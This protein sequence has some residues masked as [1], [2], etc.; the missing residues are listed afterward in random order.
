MVYSESPQKGLFGH[1]WVMGEQVATIKCS[2]ARNRDQSGD[3]GPLSRF[4]LMISLTFGRIFGF[5]P[6]NHPKPLDLSQTKARNAF[7]TPE[8]GGRSGHASVGVSLRGV[9]DTNPPQPT[10]S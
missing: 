8:I 6:W 4:S 9:A 3:L 5:S 2:S 1:V 10:R 7:S